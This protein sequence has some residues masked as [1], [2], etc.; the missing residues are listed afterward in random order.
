MCSAPIK[1]H[2]AGLFGSL[3]LRP[4]HHL[5]LCPFP[6]AQHRRGSFQVSPWVGDLAVTPG[7]GPQAFAALRFSGTPHPPAL[8]QK[9]TT[10]RAL[11][12]EL[13][14]TCLQKD[15]CPLGKKD[16]PLTHLPPASLGDL[17]CPGRGDHIPRTVAAP[18]LP[19]RKHPP[20]TDLW[21]SKQANKHGS[22]RDREESS[23]FPN[24][25][26]LNMASP[27]SHGYTHFCLIC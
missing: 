26:E 21:A 2:Q 7:T 12:R 9:H 13:G 8:F 3:Y 16:R 11:C 17:S 15:G 5:Q 14:G 24:L 18:R 20:N 23:P 27:S 4:A 6:E 25:Y 19:E 22:S 10:H 1:S